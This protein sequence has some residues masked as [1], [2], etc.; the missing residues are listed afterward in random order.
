[1]IEGSDLLFIETNDRRFGF[2][3]YRNQ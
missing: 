1:M 3:I 2:V